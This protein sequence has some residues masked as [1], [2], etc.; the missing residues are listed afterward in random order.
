MATRYFSIDVYDNTGAPLASL[1]TWVD[2]RVRA[3]SDG[4]D[5]APQ[6]SDPTI[7]AV[8]G[9]VGKYQFPCE[10]SAGQYAMGRVDCSASAYPRYQDIFIP[11]EEVAASGAVTAT[12]T[13]SVAGSPLPYARVA[14]YSGS[15]LV[16]SG[17]TGASGTV[18]L[19]ADVGTYTA[20]TVAPGYTF[21]DVSLAF[22]GTSTVSPSTISGD[23]ATLADVAAPSGLTRSVDYDAPSLAAKVYGYA[24]GDTLAFTRTITN[25]PSGRTIASATL[26][27]RRSA[28][29]STAIATPTVT[30]T[31]SGADQ[32][33]AVSWSL[34]AAQTAAIGPTPAVYDLALTLDNG[35]IR[36]VELGKIALTQGIT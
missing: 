27:V 8:S 30:V 5:I 7:A 34:T 2:Y 32:T 6:P 36:T 1:P 33:G 10:L 12:V 13:V 3:V 25:V 35:S 9:V 16:T 20:R 22:S 21:G 18:S 24:E 29:A 11:F 26:T 4:A 23:E 19:T 31:D 15:T 28:Q 17:Q 14:L